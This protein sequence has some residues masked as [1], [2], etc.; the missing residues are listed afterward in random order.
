MKG[1][2][3]KKEDFVKACSVIIRSFICGQ[4]LSPLHKLFKQLPQSVFKDC[5]MKWNYRIVKSY[6]R[7]PIDHKIR[8]DID[9]E[10]KPGA[11]FELHH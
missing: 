11:S 9:K 2:E 10:M 5:D 4:S 3:I 6:L 1:E 7:E 8:K